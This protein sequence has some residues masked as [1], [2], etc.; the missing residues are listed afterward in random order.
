MLVKINS[1]IQTSK[2]GAVNLLCIFTYDLALTSS[3]KKQIELCEMIETGENIRSHSL[4]YF[5][6]SL[7]HVCVCKQIL[8]EKEK[9]V[10]GESV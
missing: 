4:L 7:E 8:K 5:L 3:E 6:H 1:L 10:W 2:L 9:C